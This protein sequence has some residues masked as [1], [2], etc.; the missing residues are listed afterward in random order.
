MAQI[1]DFIGGFGDFETLAHDVDL[2]RMVFC[3]YGP[4]G[5]TELY[6]SIV[7]YTVLP[8]DIMLH[9]TDMESTECSSEDFDVGEHVQK[10]GICFML[11]RDFLT[12]FGAEV[13]PDF[14]L[15]ASADEEDFD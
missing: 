2:S 12:K 6:F 14:Q 4:E 11:L 5:D 3:T 10:H 15:D 7:G 8:Y 9:L 13:S 1:K